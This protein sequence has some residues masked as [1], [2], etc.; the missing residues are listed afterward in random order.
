MRS[1]SPGAL[2]FL[3]LVVFCPTVLGQSNNIQ[4][5]TRPRTVTQVAQQT[6][7]PAPPP[8][9][10]SVAPV[11]E[12]VVAEATNRTALLLTAPVIQSRITEAERLFKTKPLVTAMTT[13]SIEFVT[14]AAL[15]GTTQKTH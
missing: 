10:T 7:K 15:D 8:A 9:P 5:Q 6:V 4:S 11:K 12:V 13:P 1:N 14:V 2:I 3:A